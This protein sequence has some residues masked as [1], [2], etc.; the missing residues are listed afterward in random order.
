MTIKLPFRGQFCGKMLAGIKTMT[1]RPKRM[2]SPGDLFEAFGA[3]FR[4]THVMRM[5]LGYVGSDCFE[6]EGCASIQEFMEVWKSIHPTK[7]FHGDEIVYA[8]CFVR[9]P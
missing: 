2:G 5:R 6:Q 3:T 8:H 1:C 4:L 7:G 9:V